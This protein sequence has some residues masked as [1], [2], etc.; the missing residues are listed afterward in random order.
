M[1]GKEDAAGEGPWCAQR[2]NLLT[3]LAHIAGQVRSP[4]QGVSKKASKECSGQSQC[5]KWSFPEWRWHAPYTPFGLQGTSRRGDP[6]LPAATTNQ[7]RRPSLVSSPHA[8][9]YAGAP[10]LE[11]LLAARVHPP[12]AGSPLPTT[13]KRFVDALDTR[14]HMGSSFRHFRAGRAP[15]PSVP[16]GDDEPLGERAKRMMVVSSCGSKVHHKLEHPRPNTRRT[17][18][19][20]LETTGITRPQDR[21][22]ARV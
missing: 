17:L 5:E 8:Y 21:K 16:R 2:F 19:Y 4:A 15:P 1:G 18:N 13:R 12:N 20:P 6:A 11:P 10:A 14:R 22:I 9:Y 3:I 7:N